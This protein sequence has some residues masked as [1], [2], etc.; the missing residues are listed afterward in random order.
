MFSANTSHK[1][2]GLAILKH[3]RCM[4]TER[5]VVAQGLNQHENVKILNVCTLHNRASKVKKQKLSMFP[6]SAID[7]TLLSVTD[8]IE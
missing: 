4:M 8:G 3:P 1:N 5:G 7:F 2:T 6:V